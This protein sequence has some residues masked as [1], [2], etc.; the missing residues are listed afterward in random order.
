MEETRYTDHDLKPES[1][2]RYRMIAVDKDGLKSDP[3]D[4][5]AIPSPIVK[6]EG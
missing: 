3:V 6:S 1:Q 2:Y 5:D 4:S